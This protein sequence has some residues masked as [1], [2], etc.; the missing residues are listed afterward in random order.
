MNVVFLE[1]GKRRWAHPGRLLTN[2]LHSPATVPLHAIG[3]VYAPDR[4]GEY[5]L[6]ATSSVSSRRA[7]NAKRIIGPKQPF[8][9][10]WTICRRSSHGAGTS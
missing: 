4:G 5:E 6:R 8:K 1:G 7:L 3:G 10:K 2:L 9:P